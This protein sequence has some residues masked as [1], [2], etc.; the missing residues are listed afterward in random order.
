MRHRLAIVE[1][2]ADLREALDDFF[3][4]HG[5]DVI[6]APDAAAFRA[7]IGSDHIHI[8]ILDISM[9]GENGLALAQWLKTRGPVGIV[10][11]TA[12]G[13]PIDRVVGLD[14]GADDYVVKPY[15]LR[16]LLARVRGLIRRMGDTLEDRT[17]GPAPAEATADPAR[18]VVL[19]PDRRELRARDGRT[20]TLSEAEY[21][22]LIALLD[23]V[24][25]IVSR[26]ALALA[27]GIDPADGSDRAI[28]IRISRLRRRLA[29]LDPAI[30]AGLQTVRGE[31]Y[32]L[33]DDL[34]P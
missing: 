28:D 4:A 30:G 6:A 34:R 9:P 26:P 3:T 1:D 29:S 10:V 13:R 33:E 27:C 20:E 32:V 24:G 7:A 5:F 31:G 14:L 17:D 22:V 16:E 2:E 18:P 21:A 8:A 19:I 11:A 23:R 25:R 15:D 12:L